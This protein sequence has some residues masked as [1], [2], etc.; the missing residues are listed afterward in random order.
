MNTWYCYSSHLSLLESDDVDRSTTSLYNVVDSTVG[1]V[2]VTFVDPLLDAVTP[3]WRAL[4]AAGSYMI[5]KRVYS[6]EGSKDKA[7]YDAEA[8]KG[9]PA[10]VQIVGG[11]WEEEKVIEM[12]KV[13]DRALGARG[14][15][16]GEFTKR[17]SAL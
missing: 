5:E 17:R 12:M 4:D 9:L 1:C 10:G 7:I 6:V 14:F 16:P 8:M 11:K 15:G 3:E 13:V 2:P